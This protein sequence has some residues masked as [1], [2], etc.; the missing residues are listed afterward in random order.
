MKKA[1][2]LLLVLLTVLSLA[3]CSAPTTSEGTGQPVAFTVI[4]VDVDGSSSTFNYTSD[5]KTVGD[6]LLK[7][8]LITGTPGNPGFYL[9]SVNGITAD[10]DTESAYWAFYIGDEYASTG[11]DSTP[12][13]E[14]ATYKLVKTIFE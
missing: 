13:T 4:V 5:L 9:I 11:I 1:L 3:A 2:T 10:W 12:I 8:G 7:E 14:G 6:A